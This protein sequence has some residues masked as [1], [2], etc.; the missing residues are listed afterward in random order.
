[1]A[2]LVLDGGDQF[3][4]ADESL[5]NEEIDAMRSNSCAEEIR[6][7]FKFA[8]IDFGR[9]DFGIVQGKSVLYEINTNPMFFGQR[10]H[11]VMQRL[12]GIKI[13]WSRLLTALHCIDSEPAGTAD[14]VEVAGLSIDAWNEAK[15]M[16]QALRFPHFKLSKE[17]ERR[18][19]LT[20][21]LRHAKASVEAN[22]HTAPAFSHL[23]D[24]LM[25][26]DRIDEAIEAASRAAD[27]EARS[28]KTRIQ[29]SALLIQA[30]RYE[31]AR[32]QLLKALD[33]GGKREDICPLLARCQ[34][35]GDSG[36]AIDVESYLSRPIPAKRSPVERERPMQET[37]W[38]RRQYQQ[39]SRRLARVIGKA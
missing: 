18:G 21:A 27:L 29:L 37:N 39:F 10:N 17:H 26:Q 32:R 5:Y 24:I 13:K 4:I 8:N 36:A 25:K 34:A 16:S 9:A 31:E 28:A 35:P 12:E 11:P 7:A 6:D 33:L 22:P 23:S 14:E 19:N 1:L 20:E 38:I 3:L 15:P 2:R 30:K